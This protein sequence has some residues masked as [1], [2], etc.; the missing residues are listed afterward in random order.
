MSVRGIS[1]T[2]SVN[3]LLSDITSVHEAFSWQLVNG[4]DR[5]G[6]AD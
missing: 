3:T 4:A 1:K 6:M 5:V 2:G